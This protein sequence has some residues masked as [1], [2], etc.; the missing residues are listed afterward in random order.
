MTVAVVVLSEAEARRNRER[1]TR[2]MYLSAI[3]RAWNYRRADRELKLIKISSPAGGM[4][5]IPELAR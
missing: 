2:R 5:P 3:F 1:L 4:V